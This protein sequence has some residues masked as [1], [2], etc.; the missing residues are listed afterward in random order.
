[1]DDNCFSLHFPAVSHSPFAIYLPH[2]AAVPND[3]VADKPH[4]TKHEFNSTCKW[5]HFVDGMRAM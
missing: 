3:N 5:T 2:L 4:T 1:M